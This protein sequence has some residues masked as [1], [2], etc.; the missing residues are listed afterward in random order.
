MRSMNRIIT[1]RRSVEGGG[2]VVRR[3]FPTPEVDHIDPFL[4]LDE[5]GPAEYEP[6]KAVGAPSHPHRGFETVTY[7][8]SGAMEHE[9][10]TGTRAVIRSGGVQWMTAGSGVVHSELPTHDMMQHGGRMHGFQL[11]VNLPAKK[12][13][14]PPRYQGYEAD[15][16]ATV[17]LSQGGLIK[18]VAG[19]IHGA[20]GP[21]ETTSPMTYAHAVLEAGD[22]VEWEPEA[23]HTALVHVFDGNVTV[24]DRIID[25]GNMVVFDRTA[26]GVR[27][28]AHESRA[29]VLLLGGQPLGEPVSRYGP[30]VMNN[31]QEIVQ[32]VED[33]QSGNFIR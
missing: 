14:V 3:P 22:V 7:L 21:V 20:V 9:D 4:L 29:Q 15:E 19:V 31:R 33:Y 24:N 5:M 1:S 17:S 26:G 6:G 30:F 23:G 12:K 10:T 2:F 27:V 13:M 16:L 32:A 25:E 18:V 11:W 8:L 28:L